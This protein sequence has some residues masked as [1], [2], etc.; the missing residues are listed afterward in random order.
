MGNSK[1]LS[2]ANESMIA[3]DVDGKKYY[4]FNLKGLFFSLYDNKEMNGNSL[5]EREYVDSEWNSFSEFEEKWTMEVRDFLETLENKI[6]FSPEVYFEKIKNSKMTT[7]DEMLKN[8]YNAF[9]ILM[10]KAISNGQISAANKLM[11]H[12]ETIEKE[13]ELIKIGINS[14]IYKSEIE[15][16]VENVEGKVIK[17]IEPVS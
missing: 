10:E 13:R 15:K 3:W 12:M 11:F 17:I 8:S 6:T 5:L 4:E 1:H 7:D 9:C 14:F 2:M 16:F